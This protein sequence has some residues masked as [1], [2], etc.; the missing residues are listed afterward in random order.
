MAWSL[1]IRTATL[2][3]WNVESIFTALTENKSINRLW[4]TKW[5]INVFLWMIF[6]R[7]FNCFIVTYAG[8]PYHPSRQTSQWKPVVACW[9]SIHSPVSA[10]QIDA[11]PLHWPIQIVLVML[12]RLLHNSLFFFAI[13]LYYSCLI[14]VLTWFTIREIPV[15]WFAF[16]TSPTEGV[17]ITFALSRNFITKIIQGSN[18]MTIAR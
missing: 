14:I 5:V 12:N 8:S 2:L 9:Q 11:W 18:T 1:R 16:I 3:T 17:Y 15:S 6:R 4:F 13:F 7:R 10:S